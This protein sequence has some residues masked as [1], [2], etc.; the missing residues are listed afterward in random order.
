[1]NHDC[2]ARSLPR[3]GRR[4]EPR[5]LPEPEMFERDRAL[6]IRLGLPGIQRDEI[7]VTLTE[8]GLVVEGER[9]RE[10]KEKDGGRDAIGRPY[11]R[12]YRLIPLPDGV[13]AES[14]T[15]GF[16]AGVL[17]LTVPMMR[18]AMPVEPRNV[19]IDGEPDSRTDYL[20]STRDS[21]A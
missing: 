12:F 3:A 19:P 9:K 15:A 10:T 14:V 8:M 5:W 4:F 18:A 20:V 16:N 2:L 6:V 7:R 11:R 13:R 17:E 1:M 21:A